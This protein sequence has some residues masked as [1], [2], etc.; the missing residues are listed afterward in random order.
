M[1]RSLIG[2]GGSAFTVQEPENNIVR[3]AYIALAGALSGAQT[4]AL[5]TY[6]EAYAIPSPEAQL[7]ALRTMQICAEESGAADTVDPLAGSYYVEAL[8]NEMEAKIVEELAAVER[9]GGI[10]EAVKTGA[11]QAEVARQAYR[12]EQ[13]MLSGEIPKVAVNC[14]V[15]DR[16]AEADREDRPDRYRSGAEPVHR[17]PGRRERDCG[18]IA[19]T[20]QRSR[21]RARQSNLMPP[22]LEAVKA[23]P[24]S[25]RST[26]HSR[27][28]SASTRSR[29]D[30]ERGALRSGDDV[31]RI[32]AV[33]RLAGQPRPRGLAGAAPRLERLSPE[34]V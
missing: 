26:R 29:S 25:A 2:G 9:M 22:I 5:P 12:F 13:A 24:R 23:M 3:G 6:D 28:S 32:R 33:H 31:R 14:H 16:P 19:M 4:M 20:L 21:R 7:I 1:F 27:A 8:T 15:G 18:A 10:V 11:L 30:G 34:G 17:P